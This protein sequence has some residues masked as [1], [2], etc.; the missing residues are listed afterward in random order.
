M[1]KLFEL[2]T[3]AIYLRTILEVFHTLLLSSI[4]EINTFEHS[5]T[6]KVIS[7]VVAIVVVLF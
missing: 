5:T 4:L 1:K 6:M 3:F 2:F 7:L